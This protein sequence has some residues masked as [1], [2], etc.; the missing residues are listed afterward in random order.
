MVVDAP[1]A[2][3]PAKIP[4]VALSAYILVLLATLKSPKS[5]ASPRVDIVT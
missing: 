3:P 2:Y 1:G 5:R 4:L